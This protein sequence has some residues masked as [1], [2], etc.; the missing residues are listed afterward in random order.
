MSFTKKRNKKAIKN[1]V[2]DFFTLSSA[3]PLWVTD[4]KVIITNFPHCCSGIH[5]LT[6]HSFVKSI[7]CIGRLTKFFQIFKGALY[8]MK[9]DHTT[10][11]ESIII[12]S[13]CQYSNPL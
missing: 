8:Q 11:S 5:E 12:H 6:W 7:T 4:G 2:I 13:S 3:L 10:T 1:L 9:A